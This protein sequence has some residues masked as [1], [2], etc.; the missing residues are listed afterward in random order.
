M[1]LKLYA[2]RAERS[3]LTLHPSPVRG[4]VAHVTRPSLSLSGAVPQ[5]RVPDRSHDTQ[6][7]TQRHLLTVL[8]S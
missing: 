3:S 7:V 8:T 5:S 4:P 6:S 1:E 2:T